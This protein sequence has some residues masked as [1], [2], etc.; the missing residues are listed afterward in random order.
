MHPRV[1]TL[2]RITPDM[3]NDTN[4]RIAPF[5]H[6]ID[7]SGPSLTA[8]VRAVLGP[9]RDRQSCKHTMLSNSTSTALSR[10]DALPPAMRNSLPLTAAEMSCTPS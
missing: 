4:L 2:G 5:N 6:A 7:W 8:A 9:R 10:V 3:P 1:T